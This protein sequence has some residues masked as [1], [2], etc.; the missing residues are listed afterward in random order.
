MREGPAARVT[1]IAF[2]PGARRHC[3]QRQ[4]CITRAMPTAANSE[5]V[6]PSDM[7]S[8]SCSLAA[9]RIN[10]ATRRVIDLQSGADYKLVMGA[11]A[12]GQT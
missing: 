5:P 9:R 3:K 11:S 2:I 8:R 12:K 6:T 1:A 7:L 10:G 4:G